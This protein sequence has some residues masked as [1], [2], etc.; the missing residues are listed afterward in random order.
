MAEALRI[1]GKDATYLEFPNE[2]H[3]FELESNR[4]RWYAALIAFFEKNLAPR[5]NAQGAAA[6]PAPAAAP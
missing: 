5:E 6:E 3:G 2:I 1:A 4:V